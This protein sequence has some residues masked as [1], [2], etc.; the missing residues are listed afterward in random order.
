MTARALAF[1][2]CDDGNKSFYNQTSLFT[3]VYSYDE[4]LLLNFALKVN[5]K[6]RTRLNEI[7][8]GQWVIVIPVKQE[9]SLKLKIKN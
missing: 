9:V 5:F 7:K 8:S 3:Q 4:I 2:V 6:L 1:W